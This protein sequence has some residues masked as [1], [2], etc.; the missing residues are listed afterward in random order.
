MREIRTHRNN[1]LNECIKIEVLDEP[2]SGGASHLYRLS[3]VQG[4]LD[5]HPIPTVEIRFQ[6]GPLK[7]VGTNG[8]TN[9]ALLAVVEDRLASFQCGP[10]ACEENGLALAKIR[11]ALS[12]LSSRTRERVARGVEGTSVK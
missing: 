5:N 7:E 12:D 1:V 2:G 10:F 3:G 9:E 4:P 8:L 6:K 11:G